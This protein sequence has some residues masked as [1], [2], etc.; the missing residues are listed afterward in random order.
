[1]HGTGQRRYRVPQM[2]LQTLLINVVTMIGVI[3]GVLLGWALGKSRD[4]KE[5]SELERLRRAYQEI[6]TLS[7]LPMRF[8]P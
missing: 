4:A 7:S 8:S 1:M 2:D 6:S 3:S 5:E